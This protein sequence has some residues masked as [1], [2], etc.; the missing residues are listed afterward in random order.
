MNSISAA[1]SIGAVYRQVAI[2][3]K[4]PLSD[5]DLLEAKRRVVFNTSNFYHFSL[6][7]C[8]SF[9]QDKREALKVFGTNWVLFF[10]IYC[11]FG[12]DE[13][14][15]YKVLAFTSAVGSP[16]VLLDIADMN[17]PFLTQGQE[18]MTPAAQAYWLYKHARATAQALKL[19]KTL[20]QRLLAVFIYLRY[21]VL[22]RRWQEDLKKIKARRRSVRTFDGLR[23]GFHG[24]KAN[25]YAFEDLVVECRNTTTAYLIDSPGYREDKQEI[26]DFKWYGKRLVLFNN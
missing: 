2:S 14:L 11:N 6:L 7:P 18:L 9:M 20:R 10:D 16:Q 15:V 23:P 13:A 1:D 5:E 26:A 24:K 3:T 25:K 17:R 19:K 4:R 8:E 22:H 21:E 12:V